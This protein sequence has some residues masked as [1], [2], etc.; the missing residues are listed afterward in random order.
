MILKPKS[1]LDSAL[2]KLIPWE[3]EIPGSSILIEKLT[4][5]LETLSML[6]QIIMEQWLEILLKM[7]SKR[8]S[9]D[10]RCLGCVITILKMLNKT[11]PTIAQR[12]ISGP[13][14]TAP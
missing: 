12:L 6:G 3:Q 10:Y 7:Y 2:E 9:M 11:L 14:H 13:G 8:V 5:K 1:T 4:S